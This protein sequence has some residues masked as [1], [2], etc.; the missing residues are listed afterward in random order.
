MGVK[1]SRFN[2]VLVVQTGNQRGSSTDS[3]VFVILYDTSGNATEKMLLDNICKD[4]FKTGAHDTFF[5]NLPVSFREVAKIELWTKQCHIELT[6]SNWFIDVIEFRRHFGGNTITFPVFRWIKPEVHYYLY[7]WDAFLPHHDPDKSQR[8]AEIEY[9]CTIYKL[10]YQE[11]FPVTCEELPRD[12]EFPLKYKRGILTKK[13]DI[14][15]SAMWTKIVTGDWNTLN[16]VT[17]IYRR[18]KL[19]MPK[20]VKFWREDTWFGYQRLNGCNPTVIT[21]CEEIPSK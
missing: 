15:L 13:L 18:R 7:P 6:S 4:D 10:N 5:I 12:E 21:L 19:P 16:D 11:N 3:D 1:Q 9:K 17:N 8:A 14:I 2:N 20:S